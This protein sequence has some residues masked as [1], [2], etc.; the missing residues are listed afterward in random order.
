MPTS[1]TEP[2]SPG[3][4]TLFALLPF[5]LR[6]QIWNAALPEPPSS[7]ALYV[8]RGSGLWQPF[9]LGEAD[10]GYIPGTDNIGFRFRTELLDPLDS[11]IHPLS[12]SLVG[13]NREARL[14]ALK[15]IDK[16]GIQYNLKS[17]P[18]NLTDSH[19][20][21]QITF[22]RPFQRK[23]DALYIPHSKWDAF[24][25][26]PTDRSFQP[27]LLGKIIVIYGHE[28]E[29]IAIPHSLLTESERHDLS[30]LPAMIDQWLPNVRKLYVVFDKERFSNRWDRRLPNAVRALRSFLAGP[31]P[32]IEQ[33]PWRWELLQ[34]GH[35]AWNH[36]AQDFDYI[37][38]KKAAG[39]LLTGNVLSGLLYD[40]RL[41][42]RIVE[43]LGNCGFREE[44]IRNGIERLE[45]TPVLAVRR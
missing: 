26:E 45:V 17:P 43:L 27:D 6:D 29:C 30:L 40:R 35:I 19:F 22:F 41:L 42:Q 20:A 14:V 28:L 18:Q 16:H 44:L 34:G 10:P 2:S 1:T 31:D 24:C 5:E 25:V 13:V 4:F 3:T 38:E 9:D 8:Y 15:W 39:E 11:Q 36:T 23:V 21:Q 32:R 33:G 12:L 7:P 37:E